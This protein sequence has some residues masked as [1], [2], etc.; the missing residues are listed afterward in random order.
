MQRRVRHGIGAEAGEPQLRLFTGQAARVHG[1]RWWA[2]IVRD[3][4]IMER[5]PA[6]LT[7]R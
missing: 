3:G 5:V 6:L 2:E 4:N 1:R 7:Q